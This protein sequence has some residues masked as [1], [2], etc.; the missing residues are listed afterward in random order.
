MD[1]ARNLVDCA[2]SAAFAIDGELK[3]VAWNDRAQR[4]LGF[5][6]GDVVGRRCSEIL[7]AVLSDGESVCGLGCNAMRCLS[8]YQPVAVPEC[9]VR[10]KD[11]G[12]V[13]AQLASSV[14][15]KQRRNGDSG[16][17]VAAIFLHVDR[18]EDKA[19]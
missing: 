5:A 19:E 4:L 14:M 15:A 9:F 11:G 12:W 13:R 8:C 3:I 2:S 16:S 7:K 10:R 1:D 18:K 6:R 17:G